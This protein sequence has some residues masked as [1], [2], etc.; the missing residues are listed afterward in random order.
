M[1]ITRV[2]R[3]RHAIL[4]IDGRLDAA[5]G[6]SSRREPGRNRP[7]GPSPP[8]PGSGTRQLSEL[9]GHRRADEVLQAAQ[10]HRGLASRRAALDAG[11]ERCSRSRDSCRCSSRPLRRR[12]QPS[13]R[14]RG[15]TV[16]LAAGRFEVF[17]LAPGATLACRAIGASAMLPRSR[18][19]TEQRRGYD[20]V[21]RLDVRA[22]RGRVRREL[23]RLP[24]PLRRVARR[25]PAPPPI[26]PRTAPTR[27]T[28][29]R[30]SGLA[31]P[32][33]EAP[34]RTGLRGRGS[35]TSSGS[36][37]PSSDGPVPL[38]DL[39][40]RLPRRR[41]IAGGRA[42]SSSPRPPGLVGAALRRSPAA[43]NGRDRRT[44]SSIR[45]CASGSVSRPSRLSR[46]ARCCSS[47]CCASGDRCGALDVRVASRWRE[48]RLVG[49]FHA[50]AFPFRPLQKGQHRAQGDRH[51]ALRAEELLGVLH[52][53]TTIAASRAPARASS[54]AA[55][56]GS[57]PLHG[58][59][60]VTSCCC[61]SAR[62]RSASS[63]RCWRSASS[64]ASASSSSPTSP[65][66][67]DHA[68]RRGRRAC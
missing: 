2:G 62:S 33:A 1:E 26:S 54:S 23:R 25:R 67:L 51:G 15:P 61:S 43:E 12:R 14:E 66:R 41:R 29:S 35:R 58:G 60:V 6:R 18:T 47:A 68:R 7:R 57:V 22:G 5:L 20:G 49:H 30:R 39:A 44:S 45:A 34:L 16:E 3:R 40:R 10:P 53:L 4:E 13:R 8:A 36:I 52:L 11:R 21:P 63:C 19:Y 42:S 9:G 37:G 38:S 59:R 27:P 17:D 55:P 32:R 28:T 24:P 56:A 65:P 48:R 31:G 50:A 64:S 46:A